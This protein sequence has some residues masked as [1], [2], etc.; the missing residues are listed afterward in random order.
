MA[1]K[2]EGKVAVIT[3]G[4]GGIGRGVAL[5]AASEGARVVVNDVGRRV[6]GSS[7][8]D[9]V[10]QEITEAGGV[11]IANYDTVV[12]MAGG[13]NI[14][15][16]AVDSFGRIDSLICC[17]GTAERTVI[18][19]LTEE[20][21]DSTIAVHIKGHFTC[22]KAAAS[23][24]AKQKSGSI[25]SITSRGAFTN[26]YPAYGAAK[27]G[28][29]GYTFALASELQPYNVTVN[30]IAPSAVTPQ[31]AFPMKN[32]AGDDGIP[33]LDLSG[34]PE[35]IAP[36]VVYLCTDAAKSITGRVIYASMGDICLYQHPLRLYAANAFIRKSGKWTIDELADVIPPL[37]GLG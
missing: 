26:A 16:T 5:L 8:A 36:I 28:V 2:L 10:V 30:A 34:D 12:T 22:T 14:V 20:Q 6:D 31:F 3:G 4:G 35:Y 18:F 7:A 33:R 19:D 29:L 23:H 17:A 32:R 9:T 21:F 11:A 15:K 37:L 24:M 25:I 27:A 1:G 13:S